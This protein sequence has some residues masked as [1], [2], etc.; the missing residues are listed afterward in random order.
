M[1]YHSHNLTSLTRAITCS[2]G[3]KLVRHIMLVAQTL[4]A[5]L[6][7]CG[8]QSLL[9]SSQAVLTCD[10]LLDTR[11]WLRAITVGEPWAYLSQACQVVG[12][13]VLLREPS[14]HE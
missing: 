13:Q 6:T 8:Y 7:P 2:N 4:A 1:V 12:A 11:Q 10:N 9:N 3:K 14:P 5:E